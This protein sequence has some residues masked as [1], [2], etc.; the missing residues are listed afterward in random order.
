MKEQYLL[1]KISFHN[2][3]LVKSSQL[4]IIS[5]ANLMFCISSAS[6]VFLAICDTSFCRTSAVVANEG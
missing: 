3:R 2:F 4:S 1:L 5:S 6:V